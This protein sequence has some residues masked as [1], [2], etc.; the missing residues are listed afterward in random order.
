MEDCDEMH[1][2]ETCHPHPLVRIIYI[3]DG[4][5]QTIEDNAKEKVNINA[6]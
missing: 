3:I 6:N 4:F 1:Y 2:A 5:I